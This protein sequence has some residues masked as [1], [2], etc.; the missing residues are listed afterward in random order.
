MAAGRPTKIS[1]KHSAQLKKLMGTLQEK[2]AGR[3][4]VTSKMLYAAWKGK[5]AASLRTVF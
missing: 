2:A 3:Y 1:A 4:E 5:K